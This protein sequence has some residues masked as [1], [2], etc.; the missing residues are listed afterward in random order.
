MRNKIYRLIEGSIS[1]LLMNNFEVVQN[2][3]MI[4][5]K[6]IFKTNGLK[7]LLPILVCSGIS[8]G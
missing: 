7:L 6:F 4:F 2:L 1:N 8:T 3:K 5:N